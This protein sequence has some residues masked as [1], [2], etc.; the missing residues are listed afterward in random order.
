MIWIY[1]RAASEGANLLAEDILLKGTRARRTQ[2]RLML[3]RIQAGDTVACWG[4][5]YPGVVPQGVKT[6]NNA[7]VI[8]KFTEAQRL[9]AAGVA[10]V[11]VSRTRPAARAR[12]P[13]EEGHCN[14]Y[15]LPLN[16]VTARQ[17]AANLITFANEQDQR[18]REWQRQPAVAETWLP[19]RNNHVGGSDLLR[20]PAAPDY[21]SKKE[22][23]V[24]E[25]RLHIFNGKS[26]RAGVKRQ[27]PLTPGGAPSHP[28]IRSFDA[29]WII[30]YEG[31]RSSA[32]MRELATKAVKALGLDFGAVDLGKKADGS[33]IVLEV[34]RAP[35]VE[36]GTS[37]A[38]AGAI[39]RW[40]QGE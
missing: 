8:N 7:E 12:A 16:R 22:D 32:P 15:L 13:F 37:E 23:I 18:F 14:P 31:F 21:F 30:A 36:G 11:Q 19:R 26:I 29:G 9:A 10:T 25:Y 27:R 5:Q 4:D 1:R 39:I 3:D 6:L 35:G 34:N 33:Y 40:A 20:A 38:Y 24:E 17:A 2:G 28:W